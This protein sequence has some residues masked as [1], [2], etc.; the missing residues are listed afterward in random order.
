MARSWK[1]IWVV[2][3]VWTLSL[4]SNWVVESGAQTMPPDE[5]A[6]IIDE[7][8]DEAKQELENRLKAHLDAQTLKLVDEKFKS[9]ESGL[10][11][12]ID[13]HFNA[14]TEHYSLLN[15]MVDKVRN[16]YELLINRA[17]WVI[18][19]LVVVASFLIWKKDNNLSDIIEKRIESA[20]QRVNDKITDMER[21]VQKSGE[22]LVVGLQKFE[23][24]KTNYENALAEIAHLRKQLASLTAFKHKIGRA[25]V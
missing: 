3:I 10:A 9:A 14:L 4:S 15:D 5:A 17:A 18:G 21:D 23:A 11:Q 19:I 24:M 20:K 2:A 1:H 7:K 25:H 22:R 12:K 8:M 16:Y 6:K 13:Q